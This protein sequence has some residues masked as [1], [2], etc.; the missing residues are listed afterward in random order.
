MNRLDI[1]NQLFDATLT[2]LL[3]RIKSGDATAADFG[4]ATRFLKENGIDCLAEENDEL[5]ELLAEVET[6]KDEV[7]DDGPDSENPFKG[8]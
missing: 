3:N 2:G 6:F 5:K 4:N 7:H 8:F 1:L